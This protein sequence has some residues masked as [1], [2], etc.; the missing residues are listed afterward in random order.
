EA[1]GIFGTRL[2]CKRR[3]RDQRDGEDSNAQ[4]QQTPP[5]KLS[6]AEHMARSGSILWLDCSPFKGTK[7]NVASDSPGVGGS[8][9]APRQA[10]FPE[11]CAVLD[12]IHPRRV[13]PLRT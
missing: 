3:G 5:I 4:H 10:P 7:S 6:G 1:S 8:S 9:D 12:A 11:T 2:R 13:H